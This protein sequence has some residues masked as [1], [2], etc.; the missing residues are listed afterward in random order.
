[1]LDER[2]IRHALADGDTLR[3]FVKTDR[4][5]PDGFTVLAEVTRRSENPNEPPG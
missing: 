4:V 1:M 5:D 3:W 2:A